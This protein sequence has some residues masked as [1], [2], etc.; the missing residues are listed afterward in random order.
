[1]KN[2]RALWHITLC[3]SSSISA[4]GSSPN[5]L[6]ELWR[7]TSSR[8]FVRPVLLD[9]REARSNSHIQ[10]SKHR[11]VL[12]QFCTEILPEDTLLDILVAQDIAPRSALPVTPAGESPNPR[13]RKSSKSADVNEDSGDE[14]GEEDRDDEE[15]E[16]G[17]DEEEKVLRVRLLLSQQA[18]Y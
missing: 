5:I 16:D 3:M 13:K 18:N 8:S 2:P 6:V 4:I 7:G 14:E 12:D 15:E 1:M 17:D 10:V 9:W 11:L